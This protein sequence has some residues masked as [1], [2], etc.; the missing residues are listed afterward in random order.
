MNRRLYF[1]FP[2]AAH[3]ARTTLELEHLGFEAEHLH[4]ITRTQTRAELP[5]ATAPQRADWAG[6]LEH[7]VWAGNLILFGM[8]CATLVTLLILDRGAW[9][10][11]PLSIMLL[12]FF[13]GERFA[14]LPNVHLSEFR[15]AL[16]HGEVLL[17]V[18]VPRTRV[19]E[20]E[21]TVKGHHPE[22]VAGGSS[23]Q[24]DLFAL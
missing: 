15:D 24:T 4:A 6:H 5:D 8:A 22:A 20:V 1:L 19:A 12:S 7:W 16:H 17:M 14:R 23:W 18:D 11:L 10:L 3:A 13:A 21:Q 9:T 2:D